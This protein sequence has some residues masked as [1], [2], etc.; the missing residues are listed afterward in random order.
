MYLFHSKTLWCASDNIVANFKSLAQMSG[1]INNQE[2]KNSWFTDSYT[3]LTVTTFLDDDVLC[4]FP[5]DTS[6]VLFFPPEASL[7]YLRKFKELRHETYLSQ[8]SLSIQY[9][10]LGARLG[11]CHVVRCKFPTSALLFKV[12]ISTPSRHSEGLLFRTKES[13]PQ[14]ESHSPALSAGLCLLQILLGPPHFKTKFGPR[15]EWHP[16]HCW[17]LSQVGLRQF[18]KTSN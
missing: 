7:I 1:D 17:P 6:E 3:L 2:F 11:G 9:I 13:E 4:S 8:R 5:Y 10:P 15:P 18:C 14:S 12:A 16:Q